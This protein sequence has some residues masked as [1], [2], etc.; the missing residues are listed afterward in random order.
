LFD[1]IKLD[2]YSQVELYSYEE[3]IN[4]FYDGSNNIDVEIISCSPVKREKN[5]F[6][7]TCNIE[8]HPLSEIPDFM[9][10][11]LHTNEG[12]GYPYI[13]NSEQLRNILY[14][15]IE[16]ITSKKN[17]TE[18]IRKYGINKS[19]FFSKLHRKSMYEVDLL[20]MARIFDIDLNKLINAI[21][22]DNYKE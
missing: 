2:I 20:L 14:A 19:K 17:I 16:N 7:E 9:S 4:T 22:K 1:D 13:I 8:F 11:E 15:E 5:D 6:I 3:S 10:W 18:T 21:D 12:K